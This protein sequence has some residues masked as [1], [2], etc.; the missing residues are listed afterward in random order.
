MLIDVFINN[1]AKLCSDKE[2]TIYSIGMGI[3]ILWGG[4]IWGFG[5]LCF[6]LIHGFQ[7]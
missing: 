3:A 4:I 2:H 1:L 7:S 6:F 5:G